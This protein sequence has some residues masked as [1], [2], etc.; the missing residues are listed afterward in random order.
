VFK[1]VASEFVKG[2]VEGDEVGTLESEGHRVG[3]GSRSLSPDAQ[4]RRFLTLRL[5]E[6]LQDDSRLKNGR[7]RSGVAC[8]VGDGSDGR[9]T[10]AEMWD[11][12]KAC[13]FTP[14]IKAYQRKFYSERLVQLALRSG[15]TEQEAKA[16]VK[17]EVGC[18]HG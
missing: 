17:K 13:L 6:R 2:I 3:F 11:V 5:P 4:F 1:I 7:L 12:L 14:G 16:R 10:D 15:C 9:M 8:R 18:L